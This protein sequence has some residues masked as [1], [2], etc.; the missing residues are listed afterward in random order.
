MVA[1]PRFDL[2]P[3]KASNLMARGVHGGN[4]SAG[5]IGKILG[6]GRVS[7]A[8]PA[9]YGSKGAA[10]R[11]DGD[12]DINA[13]AA[14]VGRTEGGDSGKAPH[15]GLTQAG[16]VEKCIDA[17]LGAGAMSREAGPLPTA[18]VPTDILKK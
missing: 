16:V 10:V 1:Q 17:T 18:F 2:D 14:E 12:R 15:R 6:A 13:R 4:E 5:G 9:G 7:G 8:S 11:A 3:M